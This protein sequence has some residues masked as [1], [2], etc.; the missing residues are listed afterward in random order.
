MEWFSR[1]FSFFY[2]V[3]VQCDNT[4]KIFRETNFTEKVCFTK[5]LLFLSYY[6]HSVEKWE[7][8]SHGKNFVKPTNYLF[9]NFFSKTI[10]FTKF[11][12]KKCEREFLR[13]PYCAIVPCFSLFRFRWSL[14]FFREIKVQNDK[15]L[16]IDFTKKVLLEN[17]ALFQ[18]QTDT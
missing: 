11:L 10:A 4:W 2:T 18:K 13:F 14:N 3:Q 17:V 15:Y 8:L 12:W 1:I 9:G 16:S 5:K 6:L 7:I